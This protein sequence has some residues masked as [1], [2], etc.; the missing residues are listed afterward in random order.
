MPD[1]S[2]VDMPDQMDPALGARLRAFQSNYKPPPAPETTGGAI[3]KAADIV[4]S[5]TPGIPA[6]EN[7]VSGI[8]G[9]IGSLLDT[10][11]GAQPGTHNI[12]YQPRT[13]AGKAM[14]ADVGAATAPVLGGVAKGIANT[15]LDPED[16]GGSNQQALEEEL[17]TRIPEALG[18]VGTVTGA[19]GL[20]KG[21]LAA[22]A[23]GAAEA[24]AEPSA[25]LGLRTAEA[26]P[27]ARSIAGSS[28]REA[29]NLQNH[30]VGNSV[31][32]AQAGVPHGT[33]LSYDTLEEARG[34]PNAIYG[35]V[36]QNLPTAP[37][38]PNASAAVQSAGGANRIT[39][40]TPDAIT[41]IQGLKNQLLEPGRSFTGDQVVN[42]SR[43]LRQEGGTNIASDDVSK[44]QL[45]KA[46][47][48]MARGLEQHIA[49]SLPPNGTTSLDQFQAARTALAKNYAVQSALRGPHVDLQAL[50]R[51]QRGDP[52][53]L[54]GDM[55]TLADFAN[56]HPEVSTLPSAGT[57]YAPPGLGKDLGQVNIINPRSWI[58]PLLG[59]AARRSLT[60][61]PAEAAAAARTAPVSGLGGEFDELP[62]NA[63]HTPGE[64]GPPPPRQ[65]PLPLGPQGSGQVTNPTGGLTASSP[66]APA[67][68]AA[69]PPGQLSLADLLSHG[70]EQSPSPGLSA[71]P[72]GASAPAGIP[73]TRNAAHEAGGLTLADELGA[74]GPFKGRPMSMSDFAGV[75][76]QGVPEN[77]MARSSRPSAPEF[78]DLGQ[79]PNNASGESAASLEAQSRL[80]SEKAAGVQPVIFGDSG[81]IPLLHDVTAVDRAP[82]KGHIIL[83]ANSGKVINGGGLK[84]SAIQ[85][86]L[87]RWQV[88]RLGEAF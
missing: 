52:G 40:G 55:K 63:L 24:A 12:A 59:A 82:P 77:I 2:V 38:S 5:N 85:A 32:G 58:Q 23:A 73:F 49:D 11:T 28:G 37:L 16:I 21:P 27:I 4:G 87:N 64:V 18:A 9:G 84:P 1:G 7:I 76:S 74:G 19:G 62:M 80:G 83:D 13:T 26:S 51:V 29:L 79:R 44:Q 81:T 46:Q 54:T 67:P 31:A 20:A 10:V 69:G 17:K 15:G 43:G 36:A 8:T 53:L 66:T 35:R 71:G 78:A 25:Q 72:M 75:K 56:E 41:N 86:L 88:S 14:Q 68:P 61:S 6:L 57:R 22:R 48:D 42:E 47:L 60:G 50:A 70:V 3:K 34:A 65:P 45:G 30:Q 33:D 39:Q